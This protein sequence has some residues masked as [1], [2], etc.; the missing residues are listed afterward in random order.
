VC[1]QSIGLFGYDEIETSLKDLIQAMIDPVIPANCEALEQ[2]WETFRLK[3]LNLKS[4]STVSRGKFV[5]RSV[6]E[7]ER[8]GQVVHSPRNAPVQHVVCTSRV[9][10]GDSTKDSLSVYQY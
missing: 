4:P 10:T 3:T 2:W 7:R 5:I 9:D 8:L 6:V 1:Y